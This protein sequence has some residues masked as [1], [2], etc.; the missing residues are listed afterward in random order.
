MA[1]L[2]PSPP[3]PSTYLH[4]ARREVLQLQ[5]GVLVVHYAAV[6]ADLWGVNMDGGVCK[7]GC[8]RV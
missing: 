7:G 1:D 2:P 6:Y 8:G 5:Y 3:R 4:G